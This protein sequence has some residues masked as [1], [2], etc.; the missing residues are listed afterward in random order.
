MSECAQ[1]KIVSYFRD[2]LGYRPIEQGIAP[3]AHA[4]IFSGSAGYMMPHIAPWTDYLYGIG[5]AGFDAVL[6]PKYPTFVMLGGD[7][8][9][10]MQFGLSYALARNREQYEYSFLHSIRLSAGA[11]LIWTQFRKVEF[12]FCC[13]PS[14]QPCDPFS[15]PELCRTRFLS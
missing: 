15:F 14:V 5:T 8:G 12:H 10:G 11:E 1:R 7:A 13:G 9:V 6:L 3:L 2:T 4:W